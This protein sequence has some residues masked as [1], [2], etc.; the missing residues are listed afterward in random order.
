MSPSP[1]KVFLTAINKHTQNKTSFEG[2][3]AA[4]SVTGDERHAFKGGTR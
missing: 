1:Q 4:V 3:S 2:T